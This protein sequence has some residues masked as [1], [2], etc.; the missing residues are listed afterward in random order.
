MVYATVCCVVDDD[1]IIIPAYSDLYVI[2]TR[3]IY[4]MP[5]SVMI[6][7]DM[8]VGNIVGPK[9]RTLGL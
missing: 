5:A 6:Y 1:A 8:I 2:S 7:D 3:S 9:L 4:N